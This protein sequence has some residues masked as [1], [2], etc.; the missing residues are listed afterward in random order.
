MKGYLITFEG[1]EG[2]GKTTVMR[3][4]A[5]HLEEQGYK[6]IKTREPGGTVISEKIRDIILDINHVEM[7]PETEALLYA[8]SRTQHIAEVIKPNI[9]KGCIVLCD[10]YLDSSLVYQGYA[11]GLGIDKVLDMNK[12]AVQNALPD[13]TVF[14]D[15]K[16]RI[17]LNRIKQNHRV[18]DRLDL[19]QISFHEKVYNGYMEI[20]KRFKDRIEIV[21][22]EKDQDT[23]YNS[24][25][26]LIS[27][28]L[29]KHNE[30]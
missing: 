30:F 20:C 1:P 22:A 2:S 24:V 13:L 23:V 7:N 15:I 28:F 16:P 19:E 11:R 21:D 3:K 9:E 26:E 25:L 10:R 17:G 4:L 18:Q 14:F 6:V 29:E 27:K 8:A 5:D 12:Y